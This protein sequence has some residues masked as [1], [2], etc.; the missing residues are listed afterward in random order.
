[1]AKIGFS[2]IKGNSKISLK[3]RLI[4]GFGKRLRIAGPVISVGWKSAGYNHGKQ[5]DNRKGPAAIVTH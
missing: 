3:M 4:E 2:D 1:L 5:F